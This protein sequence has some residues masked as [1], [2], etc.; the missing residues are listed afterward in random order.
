MP[1]Q[2]DTMASMAAIR[3]TYDGKLA[4]T[5]SQ[6]AARY[7]L[8]TASMRKALQRLQGIAPLP[9]P[10]DART[11]L[12]SARELAAAMK[13]RPGKGANLRAKAAKRPPVAAGRAQG[14]VPLPGQA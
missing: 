8:D 12:Y 14:A 3:I 4:L 5:T 13:A 7:G 10:L 1:R 2:R 11:P 9:E 6:A